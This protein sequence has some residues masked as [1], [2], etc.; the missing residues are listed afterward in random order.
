MQGFNSVMSFRLGTFKN[1]DNV[2]IVSI[3]CN[4]TAGYEALA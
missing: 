1:V 4:K 2:V 3:I